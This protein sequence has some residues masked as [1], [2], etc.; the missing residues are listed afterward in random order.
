MK[1]DFHD[2]AGLAR[3]DKISKIRVMSSR[4]AFF[5]L[6]ILPILQILLI[7]CKSCS[8]LENLANPA[9]KSCSYLEHPAPKHRLHQENPVGVG[10]TR[11]PDVFAVVMTLPRLKGRRTVLCHAPKSSV[12]SV[13]EGQALALRA[14][15]VLL[16][17]REGQALARRAL[18]VLLGVGEGQALALRATRVLS[19]REGQALARRA[20]SVL[21]VRERQL[22]ARRATRV[23]RNYAVFSS[24][25]SL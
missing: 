10:S 19:V 22:L 9:C 8:S 23:I 6:T 25:E 4:T 1:Q 24:S 3:E 17:V 11:L 14:L 5:I 2:E 13:R 16:S 21:S 18:S 20:L 7:S 15:S 12:L